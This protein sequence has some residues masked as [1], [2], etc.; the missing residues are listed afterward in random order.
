MRILILFSLLLL[1]TCAKQKVHIKSAKDYKKEIL[2]IKKYAAKHHYNQ[3]VAFMIDYSL[4]SGLNRFFVMDLKKNKII[5]KGLVC[6]GDGKGKN[7]PMFATVFSNT[8]ESHC[9]SLGFS[10]VSERVYSKWGKHY[11]YWLNGLEKTNSNMR[12]R[13]V[14]LHAWSGVPDQSVYP[15]VIG[16]SFGCPTVSINFLDSLDTILKTNKKVLLYAIAPSR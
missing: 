15:K 11:K 4:H 14:V 10:L 8:N 2:T 13:V 3:D 1:A 6:H 7:N 16:T 9:S 12:K 5:K